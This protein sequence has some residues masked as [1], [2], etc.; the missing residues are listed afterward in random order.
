MADGAYTRIY[1]KMNREQHIGERIAECSPF[2]IRGEYQIVT[3][4]TKYEVE[5]INYNAGEQTVNDVHT[6]L[7]CGRLSKQL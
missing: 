5:T 1:K 3:N 7:T 4:L 6:G 2:L